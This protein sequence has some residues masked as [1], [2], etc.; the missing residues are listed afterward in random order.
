MTVLGANP[1]GHKALFMYNFIVILLSIP[2]L[3]A[4]QIGRFRL[5][6]MALMSCITRSKLV[7]NNGDGGGDGGGELHACSFMCSLCRCI[8]TS[9][10]IVSN[11]KWVSRLRLTF[12]AALTR[13]FL[14][15]AKRRFYWHKI[16][17]TYRRPIDDA[18]RFNIFSIIITIPTTSGVFTGGREVP[19]LLEI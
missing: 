4:H 13:T 10:T 19:P 15:H 5:W 11:H 3:A 17:E 6:I 14:Q 1:S 2:R 18:N 16:Y 12:N 7:Y 9:L 8:Y